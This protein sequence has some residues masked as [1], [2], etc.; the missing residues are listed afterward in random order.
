MASREGPDVTYK[1]NPKIARLVGQFMAQVEEV[2]ENDDWVESDG[3]LGK[4]VLKDDEGDQ[5]Y[6]YQIRDGKMQPT[7]SEGPFVAVM[8]MYVKTFMDLIEVALKGGD[9][10]MVFA[11]KYAG[12]HITYAGETWIVD[13]ERFRKVF[14]RLSASAALRS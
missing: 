8:T 14:K 4:M 13:S 10:E 2:A 12:R 5:T 3:W 6:V 11:Q 1:Q 9:T 7:V